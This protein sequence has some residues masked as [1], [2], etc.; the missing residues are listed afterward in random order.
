LI[1]AIENG[2]YDIIIA[3]DPA[4]TVN[5]CKEFH[6]DHV[7]VDVDMPIKDGYSL[8]KELKQSPDT[9]DIKVIIIKS[10]NNYYLPTLKWIVA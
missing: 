10:E 2:G 6:P 1:E 9:K 8:S 4:E 5:K 3:S 7:I